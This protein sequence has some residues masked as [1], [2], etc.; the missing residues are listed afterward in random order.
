VEAA[1]KI[2][3]SEGKPYASS[4]KNVEIDNLQFSDIYWRRSQG[5]SPTGENSPQEGLE[6]LRLLGYER[7]S[8]MSAYRS[9]IK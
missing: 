4:R 8:A 1:E 6:L 7:G 3:C 2:A 9:S 5:V